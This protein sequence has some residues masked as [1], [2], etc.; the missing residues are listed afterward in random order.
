MGN[1]LPILRSYCLASKTLLRSTSLDNGHGVFA[2]QIDCRLRDDED[3]A[4]TFHL[5]GLKHWKGKDF[6]LSQRQNMPRRNPV[7]LRRFDAHVDMQAKCTRA[8][9]TGLAFDDERTLIAHLRR[10]RATSLFGTAITARQMRAY[11]R[12]LCNCSADCRSCWHRMMGLWVCQK[13]APP[14]ACR[15]GGRDAARYGL[16]GL[17]HRDP[18][19]S[20][21]RSGLFMGGLSLRLCVDTRVHKFWSRIQSMHR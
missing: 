21:A 19:G 9:R 1:G 14:T 8:A 17:R 2:K 5:Y 4:V 3:V 13:R 16:D 20:R 6:D 11:A 12:A 18:P 7:C 10:S 15:R